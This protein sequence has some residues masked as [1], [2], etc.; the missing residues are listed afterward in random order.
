MSYP[1]GKGG[2][3]IAQ[4]IIS[5]MPP[6]RVYIEPFLGHGAVLRAKRPAAVNIGL[7]LDRAALLAVQDLLAGNGERAGGLAIPDAT[8]LPAAALA[9]KSDRRRHLL[10]QADALSF[11]HAYR[12][13][14]DELM[15]CDPPYILSTCTRRHYR[16]ILTDDQHA[17]LLALLVTIPC[18]ILISHY[19]HPL[20][21]Q[22]LHDWNTLSY[23]AMTRG[24]HAKTE[25]LW[26]NFEPP[27]T[28]HDARYVGQNFR[29]RER[30]KRRKARW[31]R[32]IL[33]MP[34][35]ERQALYEALTE[36]HARASPDVAR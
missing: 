29:E 25:H 36:A 19:A 5:L 13:K 31:V 21:A 11:L 9:R 34:A 6:H 1:G 3:G 33:A 23:P 28:L 10:I 2:A 4:R 20:Y 12:F 32:R 15:Y 30:I 16:H 22:T 17:E 35:Y 7:D 18:P 26:L 14:G 24:G 27:S 8:V